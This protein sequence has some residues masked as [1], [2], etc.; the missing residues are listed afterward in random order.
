MLLFF[1]TETTG[2]VEW[3]KPSNDPSQ[4]HLVQLAALL[5][6]NEG[7]ERASMNCIIRPDGWEVSD[8]AAAV[9][10][11][12]TETCENIGLPV[13]STLM[14][15]S[16]MAARAS[17]LVAYNFDFDKRVLKIAFKR[18]AE[19]EQFTDPIWE[20]GEVVGC[21]AMKAATPVCKIPHPTRRGSDAWKWPKLA[22]AHKHLTGEEMVNAHD[23]MADVRATRAVY[24]ELMARGA[25]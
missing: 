8:E 23:A 22:E 17:R 4:P 7:N 11:I 24:L 6:D 16:H 1:D 14:L 21:C 2:M 9:H 15:F 13:V 12:T 3:R 10:G 18:L 25:V 20:N 19:T 5:T